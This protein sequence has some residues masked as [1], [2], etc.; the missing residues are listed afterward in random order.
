MIYAILL[1]F[2]A[3]IPNQGFVVD[4]VELVEWNHY[5]DGQGRHVFEQLIFWDWNGKKGKHEIVDWRMYKHHG[6]IPIKDERDGMYKVIWHDA[7]HGG[8]WRRV[9]AKYF[10]K[11]FTQYDPEL[12]ERKTLAVGDRRKLTMPKGKL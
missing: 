8:G 1:S 5:Y 4:E 9:N 2:A 12:E 11:T 10:R 6:M 3:T 7:A